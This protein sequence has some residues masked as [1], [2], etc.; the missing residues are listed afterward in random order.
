MQTAILDAVVL[1]NYIEYIF[2]LVLDWLNTSSRSCPSFHL[3]TTLH[4]MV[5]IRR[6]GMDSGQEIGA[7][8]WLEFSKYSWISENCFLTPTPSD[9]S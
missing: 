5:T 1:L 9:P 3:A 8:S 6:I 2:I 7:V 4:L